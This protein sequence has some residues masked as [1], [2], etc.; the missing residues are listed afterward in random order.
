M[1]CK[2]YFH[3]KLRRSSWEA[4][5]DVRFFHLCALNAIA[6]QMDHSRSNKERGSQVSSHAK[7]IRN[8][9]QHL[10]KLDVSDLAPQN[11]SQKEKDCEVIRTET[12]S[13]DSG[14]WREEWIQESLP[15][16]HDLSSSDV[17]SD[18]VL[19]QSQIMADLRE[20]LRY[21]KSLRAKAEAKL[22]KVQ[23]P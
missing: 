7:V 15:P 16:S 6:N 8:I 12:S 20:E 21:E 3:L 13:K 19:K 4:I 2:H 10:Y 17:A 22:A 11:E 5:S 9:C 1:T 23:G 18:I 14:V